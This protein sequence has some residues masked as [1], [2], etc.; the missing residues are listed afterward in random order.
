M[1]VEGVATHWFQ[2]VERSVRSITWE[3]FCTLVHDRF[4]RDQHEA[5]I[6]QLFHIQQSGSVSEYVEQFSSIV[7]Q[8]VAYESGANPL[9]YAM[10]FVDGLKENI[11]KVVM[12]QM[13]GDL[14]LACAFAMVQEEASDTSRRKDYRRADSYSY[15]SASKPI[16]LSLGPP[17]YDKP[18]SQAVGED[19]YVLDQQKSEST[20]DE[21]KALRQYRRACGLRDRCAEK[22]VF[23]H[24]CAPTVQLHVV[25][26]LWEL[27]S[28]D[29]S[30]SAT[31]ELSNCSDDSAQLCVC[32]SQA[33]VEGVESPKFMRVMGSIQGVAVMML[34]DS[35][36]SHTFISDVVAA[37][38]AGLSS[39][40][41]AMHVKV[42]NGDIVVCSVQV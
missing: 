8:L 40:A 19:T 18:L 16:A 4:G 41:R 33:D 21:I 5:I 9:Y 14:D 23:G 29:D 24:K 15:R 6:R 30:V 31:P 22:W 25:Q 35:C 36:S 7:D 26:E 13:P 12:I 42:A 37:K 2:S 28:V 1:H 32:I 20:D 17:R 11:R 38:L 39:L 10:W 34:I 3:K 27:I